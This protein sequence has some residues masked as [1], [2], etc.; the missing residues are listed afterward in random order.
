MRDGPSDLR[1]LLTRGLQD[2]YQ[3]EHSSHPSMISVLTAHSSQPMPDSIPLR[4]DSE[5]GYI[6]PWLPPRNGTSCGRAEKDPKND[7]T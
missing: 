6:S 7:F 5:S 1:E 2:F 3:H 4:S